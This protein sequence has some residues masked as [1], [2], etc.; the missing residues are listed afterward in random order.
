MSIESDAA[1]EIRR[2]GN[3]YKAMAELADKIDKLGSIRDATKQAD[4]DRTASQKL[5]DQLKLEV[6]DASKKLK[7][8][9]D[10]AE[11]VL[12][13]A[14]EKA[15]A[16]T[17]VTASAAKAKAES[18]VAKAENKA[19][20]IDAAADAAQFAAAAEYEQ[21]VTSITEKQATLDGLTKAT[22]AKQSEVDGLKL[23]LE[24]MRAKFLGN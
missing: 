21:I 1:H 20:G 3:Q 24:A 14:V 22:A 6:A 13:D 7:A 4:T 19:A 18:I 8:A 2:L 15:A 16:D 10:K 17:A 5:L 9:K 23:E 11:Q 12:A